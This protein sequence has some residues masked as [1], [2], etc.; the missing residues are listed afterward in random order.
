[1]KN[2]S[3]IAL[4]Y[5]QAKSGMEKAVLETA[6]EASELSSY[7]SGCVTINIHQDPDNPS[8]FMVYEVWSDA[9]YFENEHSKQP[10]VVSGREKVEELCVAPLDVKLWKVTRQFA[11]SAQA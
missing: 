2:N 8:H 3:V 6:A 7:E 9:D 1:M 4:V 5:F 11:G 10:Y